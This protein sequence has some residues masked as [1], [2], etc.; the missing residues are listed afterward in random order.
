MEGQVV[1]K[2]DL[3]KPTVERCI[4]V[5]KRRKVEV[6]RQAAFPSNSQF[7]VDWYSGEARGLQDAIQALDLLQRP[8][9]QAAGHY[10]YHGD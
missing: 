3:H 4:E 6:E 1:G 8:D 10:K 7:L 2:P 9:Y 5:L